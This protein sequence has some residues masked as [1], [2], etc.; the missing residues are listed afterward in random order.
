ISR[1]ALRVAPF[2]LLPLAA[3]IWLAVLV[4]DGYGGG[5]E[6]KAG[7]DY[8][9][10]N[11]RTWVDAPEPA[12]AA[13][14]VELELD[15]ARSFLRSKG[16]FTL[17]NDEEE[18]LARFAMTEGTHWTNTSWSV[19]GQTFYPVGKSH[20]VV[21]SLAEA[22][23]PGAK[24]ELGFSFEG[25][26]PKGISKNGPGSSE[27]VLPGGAVLTS[28]AP[29]FVP[30]VGFLEGIGVEKENKTEPKDYPDDFYVGVTRSGFGVDLPYPVKVTV[31]GPAEYTYN[32]VG[33]KTSD[34]V[35]GGVR[36]TTW[37]TDRPVLFFNV[38]AGRWSESRGE[39]VAI[40]HSPEHAFNIPAM[41]EAL[42][43]ARRWYGEWFSPFPWSE[44][45]LSEFPG[46]A[47][48]AQGFP[49]NISFSETIGFLT[50]ARDDADAPFLVT[51]HESAHQWWGN[52]VVPGKG[53]GGDIL[54]EGA[55]PFATILLFEQVKG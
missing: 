27:F 36:S 37:E 19:D 9:S 30:V 48:Y 1:A 35:T 20:L 38:V 55:S 13:A 42:S 6:K 16:T 50:S 4:R 3:G 29:T 2:A 49:T 43:A 31:R 21:F 8:W 11:L 47:D 32:S 51:A 18:A 28:F 17:V 22:L 54:S 45:K 24:L 46:Y 39:G 25:V 23:A 26:F 7:K 10:A 5:R 15:P 53:P 34:T 40:Y 12:I 41:T 44:L 33:V 14:E 52:R